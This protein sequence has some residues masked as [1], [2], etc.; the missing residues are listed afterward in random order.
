MFYV[1]CEINMY[2][3]DVKYCVLCNILCKMYSLYIRIICNIECNKIYYFV[4]YNIHYVIML[5]N[6][7][8]VLYIMFYVLFI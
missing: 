7:E 6:K 3:I 8:N 2:Y 1:K 5:C 4:I